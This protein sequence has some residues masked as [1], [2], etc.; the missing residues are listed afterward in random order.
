MEKSAIVFDA[1][2]VITYP[3]NVEIMS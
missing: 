2:H 1:Y 3:E